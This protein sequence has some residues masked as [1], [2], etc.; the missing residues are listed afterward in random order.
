MLR[1][2]YAIECLIISTRAELHATLGISRRVREFT[3]ARPREIGGPQG[4]ERPRPSEEPNAAGGGRISAASPL[5]R[6]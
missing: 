5:D 6:A 2:G 1:P 4:Y 3:A